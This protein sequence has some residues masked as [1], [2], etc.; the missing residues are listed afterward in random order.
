MKAD[1]ELAA[2]V[3]EPANE[4]T[5][6]GKHERSGDRPGIV[7]DHQTVDDVTHAE[8]NGGV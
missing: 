4:G 3:E 5:E 7:F 6:R 1:V 2:F 8:E